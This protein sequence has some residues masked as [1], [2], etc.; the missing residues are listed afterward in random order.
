[1][2]RRRFTATVGA[3]LAALTVVPP[4]MAEA[5]PAPVS[6]PTEPDAPLRV[7][8][9]ATRHIRRRALTLR[10][11]HIVVV[12]HYPP[13]ADDPTGIRI[14]ISRDAGEPEPAY[15]GDLH[16]LG[17]L[18]DSGALVMAVPPDWGRMADLIERER[19]ALQREI[20]ER[21]PGTGGAA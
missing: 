3:A 6:G 8:L 11:G 7:A 18:L 13:P 20:E 19:V 16:A 15:A 10:K 9:V 2:N 12:T 21:Q 17:D 5:G 4:G 14:T 1:V